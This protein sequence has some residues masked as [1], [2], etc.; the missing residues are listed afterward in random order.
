[1]IGPMNEMSGAAAAPLRLTR[2]TN[3]RW[4]TGVCGGIAEYTGI[5]PTIVRVAVA[6][7]AL[8][9]GGG[10]VAYVLAWLL[11]PSADQAQSRADRMVARVRRG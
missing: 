2:S 1:M 11:I 8:C 4:L 7:L 9:G 5:D 6:I 10:V 3:D